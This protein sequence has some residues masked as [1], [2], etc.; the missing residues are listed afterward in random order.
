MS[1]RDDPTFLNFPRLVQVKVDVPW[2]GEREARDTLILADMEGI[3]AQDVEAQVE[4]P[5]PSA[6]EVFEADAA[7]YGEGWGEEDAELQ[8]SLDALLGLGEEAPLRE[9]RA[10]WSDA[11]TTDGFRRGL[12]AELGEDNGV[13]LLMARAAGCESAAVAQGG[14]PR[15]RVASP[16]TKSDPAQHRISTSELEVLFAPDPDGYSEPLGGFADALARQAQRAGTK[17]DASELHA[18]L[19][20]MFEVAS[21]VRGRAQSGSGPTPALALS[22]GH[23]APASPRGLG[24]PTSQGL[25][26]PTSHQGLG[27]SSGGVVGPGQPRGAAAPTQLV[28]GRVSAGPPLDLLGALG[29]QGLAVFPMMEAQGGWPLGPVVALA[30]LLGGVGL[31]LGGRGLLGPRVSRVCLWMSSAL[32]LAFLALPM[33]AD[34]L[35]TFRAFGHGLPHLLGFLPLWV[36]VVPTLQARRAGGLV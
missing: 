1:R 35:G 25:G 17:L 36:A 26:A 10:G 18:R 23:A 29:V 22:Q 6:P 8:G 19:E 3:A 14:S 11:P 7:G 5:A 21:A 24:A 2:V 33:L 27:A 16:R 15:V 9:R 34:A 12:R 28:V 4:A 13:A 32:L 30:P 31:W 20:C